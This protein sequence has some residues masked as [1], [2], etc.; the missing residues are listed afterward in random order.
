[1]RIPD[2]N[3]LSVH[4]PERQTV[5]GMNGRAVIGDRCENPHLIEEVNHLLCRL[6]V[7]VPEFGKFHFRY[8]ELPDTEVS[9]EVFLLVV[10]WL[11]GRQKEKRVEGFHAVEA[12][13]VIFEEV[14]LFFGQQESVL[15]V[16]VLHFLICL[17]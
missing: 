15:Y 17:W 2:G 1:M 14:K 6:A 7:T 13:V 10:K 3:I 16:F 4:E 5:D 12:L 9:R 11:Y 8:G